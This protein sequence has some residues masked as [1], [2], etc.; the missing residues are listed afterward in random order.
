MIIPY[1]LISEHVFSTY[2]IALYI[3][4]VF[5]IW[6][7]SFLILASLKRK[8]LWGLRISVCA[9]A[10]IGFAIGLGLF[11]NLA[12]DALWLQMLCSFLFY[13]FILFTLFISFEEPPIEILL[14][15]VA[16]MAIRECADGIDTLAKLI[17]NVPS[18][19]M[20][21]I[22]DAHFAVNG[23]IFDA[24]H[25]AVQL[26]LGFLLAKYKGSFKDR[27]ILIRTITLSAS[28][29]VF[30]IVIKAIVL[31]YQAESKA[32][33]GASVGLTLLLSAFTLL[34]RTDI[35]IG[36][37]KSREIATI[38]AILESQQK[39]FEE[40]KQSIALINAKVHDI[41]HRID[42]FG[43]KVAS[44]TLDQLKSSIEIYDRPF[45]TGSQVL[46]TILYT[47]SLECDALKI[48]ITAIGDGKPLH[49][50][51]SSKRFYLFSNIIDNAI[52]ATREVKNEEKRVIGI[53]L[54]KEAGNFIIEE[55]N[56]FEGVRRIQNG[57]L[58]T[59]KSDIKQKHGM[60]LKSIKAFAEEY[61]GKVEIGLNND[62]FFLTVTIPL[63]E[64]D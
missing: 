58:P 17:F 45:H 33:Y 30:A 13:G 24:I 25:L 14:A 60:G 18:N 4:L 54:R 31:K 61:G 48:R 47:K 50:I 11:R 28:L 40:S 5:E 56:Y 51:P 62:M 53:S 34:L 22:P 29:M 7:S 63:K 19:I 23:L 38:N 35:L 2:Y 3:G 46:D 21:Y 20:G 15:W 36:S 41:R 57:E 44:D 52:E 27:D 26:P 39:Q 43:D 16:V 55:Y 1:W 12:P 59:T 9:A 6:A 37:Q 49:F 10:N 42:D 8:K 32:L 64:V